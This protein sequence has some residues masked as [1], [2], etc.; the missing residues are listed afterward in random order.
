M[1][2]TSNDFIELGFHKGE[3]VFDLIAFLVESSR[4]EIMLRGPED[5]F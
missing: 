5:P 2:K 3:S 1:T 4:S